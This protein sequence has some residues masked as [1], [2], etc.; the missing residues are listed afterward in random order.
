ME[1]VLGKI[2]N[3]TRQRGSVMVHGFSGENP[4]HMCPP[5]A[6]NWR[7]GITVMIRK[8]MM[9]AMGCDPENRSAFEGQRRAHRHEILDP[10]RSL[11]ATMGQ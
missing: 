8:L 11:I 7:M 1:F 6:V 4:S 2:G 10:L 5:F 3:I 9:N